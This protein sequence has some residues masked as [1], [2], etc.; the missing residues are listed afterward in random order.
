MINLELVPFTG[1]LA[2]ARVDAALKSALAVSDRARECAVL[3]F[4]EVARRHL[5]RDLAFASLELYA[6]D[7][8]GFSRDRMFQFKRLAA[9]LERL[10]RL[11]EAVVTGE[12]GWTKAQQVAR[13]ATPA[14]E[15]AWVARAWRK[16]LVKAS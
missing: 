8:L 14:S 4:A 13:V 11:Q 10:P 7:G 2:A 5:Y 16:I 6:M 9:D 3:W 15:E 1:G 12:I